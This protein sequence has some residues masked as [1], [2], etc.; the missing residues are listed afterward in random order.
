MREESQ[1]HHLSEID[2][3]LEGERNKFRDVKIR[4]ESDL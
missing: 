2:N 4:M 3:I 1:M